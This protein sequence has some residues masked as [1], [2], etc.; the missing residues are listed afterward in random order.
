MSDRIIFGGDKRQI[1]LAEELRKQGI[2]VSFVDKKEDFLKKEAVILAPVPFTKDQIT[3]FTQ[4]ENGLLVDEFLSLLSPGQ[5]LFGG[6]LPKKVREFC[7][8]SQISWADYME[9]EEV[10]I[11]NAVATAEGA[12]CEAIKNSPLNLHK[13]PCLLGG[14]GRCGRILAQKLRG[15]GAVVTVLDWDNLKLAQAEADGFSAIHADELS[16]ISNPKLFLFLFN[17]IPHPVFNREFL[18]KTSEFLAILDLSSAPGG[19]DMDYCRKKKKTALLCP[20]LPGKYSPL[21]SARILCKALL[22]HPEFS[23]RLS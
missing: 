11:Q 2:S 8:S 18:E 20:G 23:K 21:T 13:S 12:V 1:F 3:C 15:M 19:V 17:T 4:K 16:K 10:C 22:S 5:L 7:T 6:N 9:M 14:Y